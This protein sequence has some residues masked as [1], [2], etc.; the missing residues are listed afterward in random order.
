MV[1]VAGKVLGREFPVGAHRRGQR[2]TNKFRTAL[3]I[4]EQDVE[5]PAEV[6]Q[7]VVQRTHVR[8][9]GG[10][11]Q[12]LVAGHARLVQPPLRLV[13]VVA[14]LVDLLF[15]HAQQA[16]VAPERPAVVITDEL[17]GIALVGE[18]HP[19]AAVRTG[20]EHDAD[21][22]VLGAAGDHRILPH[23]GG[24]EV[25][26]LWHLR[27]VADKQPAAR[28]DPL[29]LERIDAFIP[30]DAAVEGAALQV[31]QGAQFLAGNACAAVIHERPVFRVVHHI[32]STWT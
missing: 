31:D 3:V 28:E 21:R 15:V 22:A 9:E 32:C 4:V 24:D 7:I 1:G 13:E 14:F 27:F 23:I 6:A 18:T 26:L 30:E 25:A 12:A 19:V 20:V 17:A 16:A 8:V 10:E 11:H 5:I 2:T 29:Q